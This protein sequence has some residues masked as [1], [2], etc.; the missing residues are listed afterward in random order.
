[1]AFP[2]ENPD[3][4]VIEH[5]KRRIPLLDG[6]V[7][8]SASYMLRLLLPRTQKYELL[9]NLKIRKVPEDILTTYQFI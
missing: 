6:T 4:T 9:L 1:M 7:E 5:P 2:A 8:S 3:R